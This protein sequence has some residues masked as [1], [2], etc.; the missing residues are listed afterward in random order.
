MKRTR[1]V[2]LFMIIICFISGCSTNEK[3]D[4]KMRCRLASDNGEAVYTSEIL[5]EYVSSSDLVKKVQYEESHK[6]LT[7][8]NTNNDILSSIMERQSK[9]SEID[10]IEAS[11]DVQDT[12]FTTKEVWDL[13]KV[14]PQDALDIDD[15]QK[16]LME[17]GVYTKSAFQQHLQS[18]KGYSCD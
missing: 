1:Q 15:Q 18:D 9:L 4:K 16:Y 10:G 11:L 2:I 8:T 14:N 17:D 5:F 6:N 12:S 13:D 7:K 3:P